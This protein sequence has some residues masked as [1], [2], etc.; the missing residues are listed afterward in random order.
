MTQATLPE[1]LPEIESVKSA[2]ITTVEAMRQIRVVATDADYANAA[3]HLKAGRSILKEI[4][5]TMNPLVEAAHKAHK[6][7]TT[8]RKAMT[9][10]VEQACKQIAAA[11]NA[12]TTEKQRIERERVEAE[13]RRLREEAEARA[14]AEAA[15]LEQ[16]AAALRARAEAAEA[17]NAKLA[18]ALRD[19]AERR[20]C[21][22]VEAE[23][24]VVVPTV[25]AE[26]VAPKI[27]GVSTRTVW[28]WEVADINAIPRE[29]FTLDTVKIAAVVRAKKDA[30]GIPGIRATS[31]QVAAVSLR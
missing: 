24:A 3:E 4:E 17:D 14:A 19:T 9:D 26:R 25:S 23:T 16:E 12:Y 29:Y 8:T 20:E 28:D 27:D 5:A 1:T 11:M 6:A 30:H 21:E 13:N 2:A 18:A 22:A 15:R 7:A 31:R 10:P